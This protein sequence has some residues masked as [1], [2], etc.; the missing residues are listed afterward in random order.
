MP[1]PA[2]PVEKL[3]ADYEIRVRVPGWL[4]NDILA[5]AERQGMSFGQWC[6]VALYVAVRE[7]GGLP[8]RPVGR[9]LPGVDDVLRAYLSGERLLMPCGVVECGFVE[10]VVGG[11]GFCGVCGVRV[12]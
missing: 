4:K 9:G 1:R 2:K 6:A 5:F 11:V 7:G 10:E 12:G 3:D 8:V